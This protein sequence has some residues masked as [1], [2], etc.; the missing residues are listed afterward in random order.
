MMNASFGAILLKDNQAHY[1]PLTS[2]FFTAST[3]SSVAQS[4]IK[5]ILEISSKRKVS[6]H[7][8]W[9]P[10]L[11]QNS[12]RN[13]HTKIVNE[14][15]P[16][17][18]LWYHCRVHSSSRVVYIHFRDLIR[19]HEVKISRFAA[20]GALS[21]QCLA[22]SGD[23]S[24]CSSQMSPFPFPHTPGNMWV[25]RCDYVR[26]LMNPRRFG[27][28]LRPLFNPN[29]TRQS[30]VGTKKR[31]S[32]SY[33]I[34]SH[35]SVRPC[36]LYNSSDFNWHY[37]VLPVVGFPKKKEWAPRLQFERYSKKKKCRL[38]LLEERLKEYDVLYKKAPPSSWWGWNFYSNTEERGEECF[39][40]DCTH[41][42]NCGGLWHANRFPRKALTENT[43]TMIKVIV[44]H[45]QNSLLWLTDFIGGHNI[46]SIHV[47]SKCGITVQ[48]APK[49]STILELPN[50]GRCDHS[51]VYYINHFLNNEKGGVDKD[52]IIFFLKDDM[53]EENKHQRGEWNNFESMLRSA[54]SV[55]GFSCGIAE[56]TPLSWSTTDE[57][58]S[59]FHSTEDLFEFQMELY[60]RNM[61]GYAS[62]TTEF[63][64]AF[65]NLGDF[66]RHTSNNLY[67]E[68]VQVCYGG[69][70]AVSYHNIK[71]INKSAWDKI[72]KLLSR[73]NNIEEGHFMERAWAPMLSTPNLKRYQIKALWHH[74]GEET[75]VFPYTGA[76]VNK[77]SKFYNRP[78]KDLPRRQEEAALSLGFDRKTWNLGM[79]PP[80]I[81]P[82]YWKLLSPKQHDALIS[83]GHTKQTWDRSNYRHFQC[84][85][86]GKMEERKK[87]WAVA[88]IFVFL[89]KDSPIKYFIRH[90]REVVTTNN[91][92]FIIHKT[93]HETDKES[94]ESS[95]LK[96][97]QTLGV[98]VWQCVGPLHYK[99][100]MWS[101]VI[102]YYTS[103]SNFV[104][105][106]NSN[107]YM[108]IRNENAKKANSSMS[109]VWDQSSFV[110]A[111]RSLEV[112]G[113]PFKMVSVNVSKKCHQDELD[114]T[115][116][117][118]LCLDN[119][120]ARDSGGRDRFKIFKCSDKSFMRGNEFRGTDQDNVFGGDHLLK[121]E[122]KKNQNSL[123]ENVHN[124]RMSNFNLLMLM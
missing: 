84:N 78:W 28:Q 55:N 109:L 65:N 107:E 114:I 17:E 69:V 15:Q 118:R 98:D 33:W 11:S 45:C 119:W 85:I 34:Y 91:I 95:L 89:E 32:L 44:S 75:A 6:L 121:H 70:F 26:K 20:E 68:L 123:I 46:A 16:L 106:L 3:N 115:S 113:K 40:L 31:D 108:M 122:C 99:G 86:S 93:T 8:F 117:Y 2:I 27:E 94:N 1:N 105:P 73:G 54:S 72:E 97:Y 23:C 96:M 14:I 12:T 21:E 60:D 38:Q 124:L 49:N 83:L 92:V 102:H 42:Q 63:Q 100:N 58:Y 111:L 48:G 110:G 43:R 90:Y 79:W 120:K 35:P 112:T 7:W 103:Y 59:A 80:A 66:I 116:S 61:K 18:N 71:T 88:R 36:D 22:A 25:A 41:D 19:P 9:K 24:V 51:Y 76:L 13:R 50:V 53:S 87:H 5:K 101:H 57:S 4:F 82:R 74:S 104:F 77:R 67:P 10:S 56:R 81:H 62:N 30:C 39:C 64:S 37:D 47:I 29:L 52:T